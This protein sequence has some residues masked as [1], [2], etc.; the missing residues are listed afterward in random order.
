MVIE[1]EEVVKRSDLFVD[2]S[3]LIVGQKD[4]FMLDLY[5]C[6]KKFGKRIYIKKGTLQKLEHYTT[7]SEKASLAREGVTVLAHYEKEGL[8]GEVDSIDQ[9]SG[10]R[11][12]I[13]SEDK[14]SAEKEI[15]ASKY[16]NF[17]GEITI[18]KIEKGFP[19]E[20]EVKEMSGEEKQ[21]K[22]L[23]SIALDNSASMKGDKMDKLR[24]AVFAF[25]DRLVREGLV[26]QIEFSTIVFSGFNCVVAKPFEE[27]S[28]VKEKFFAGGIP[29]VD[30]SIAKSIEKI[31][32]RI[33]CYDEK[34]ISYYK[35]WLIV[36]SNGENFGDVNISAEL[37]TRMASEGRLTYFPFALSDREFDNSLYPLR[38]LKKF[39]TIKNTMYESLFNWIFELARKR[40]KT[41]IDQSFG[42]DPS[43]YDGWTIK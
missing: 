14:Q 21:A 5:G 36:L 3:S 27:T 42:I 15:E 7:F 37:I 39:I 19:V 12:C 30:L 25:N 23:I 41:P 2:V 28:I 9:L 33:E 29:F 1:L 10:K 18:V 24:Q 11:L 4:F 31:K 6:L 17:D 20:I 8:L 38:K 13:V 32:E 22:L 34:N 43:S 26:D 40:V 35:P 16:N